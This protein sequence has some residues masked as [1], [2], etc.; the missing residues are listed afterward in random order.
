MA[1]PESFDARLDS[2]AVAPQFVGDIPGV[3][4]CVV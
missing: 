1:S 3:V 2:E 4:G